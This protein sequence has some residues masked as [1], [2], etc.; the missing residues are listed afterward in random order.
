MKEPHSLNQVHFHF[1]YIS[2]SLQSLFLGT[3]PSN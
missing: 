3:I 2:H 1:N